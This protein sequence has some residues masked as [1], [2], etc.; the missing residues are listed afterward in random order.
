MQAKF[1]RQEINCI[2]VAILDHKTLLTN[3][4]VRLQFD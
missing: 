1:L 4:D 3:N 2:D